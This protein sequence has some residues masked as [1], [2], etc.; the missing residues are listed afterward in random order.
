MSKPNTVQASLRALAA[1]WAL[2]LIV[3]GMFSPSAAASITRPL[4][5]ARILSILPPPKALPHTTSH[6]AL[7]N[8]IKYLENRQITLNAIAKGAIAPW[9]SRLISIVSADKAQA[10]DLIKVSK[11]KGYTMFFELVVGLAAAAR[12]NNADASR[13]AALKKIVAPGCPTH[14]T[15]KLPTTTQPT[16]PALPVVGTNYGSAPAASNAVVATDGFVSCIF[17]NHVDFYV[18]YTNGYSQI[19]P[20][21]YTQIGSVYWIAVDTWGHRLPYELAVTYTAQEPPTG[22]HEGNA[23]GTGCLYWPAH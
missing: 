5:C 18:K 3:P 19:V 12:Y 14:P 16:H 22:I 4:P 2:V 9:R 15:P 8:R 7:L 10:N 23:S 17:P 13:L 21:H 20:V 11:A 6:T 1:G